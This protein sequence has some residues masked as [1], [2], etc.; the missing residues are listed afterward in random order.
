MTESK[1]TPG[2]WVVKHYEG[3]TIGVRQGDNAPS[4]MLA[5]NPI[6]C[7]FSICNLVENADST[8]ANAE[9]IASAPDLL[10][11]NE[12]MRKAY[13]ILWKCSNER[14]NLNAELVKALGAAQVVMELNHRE[15]YN[16]EYL[17]WSA[18]DQMALDVVKAAL[19]K[20]KEL[21]N[22]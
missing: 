2:P 16:N 3:G 19:A 9:L 7:G 14:D 18:E 10:D 22:D 8:N 12:Q 21:S 20:A 4:V 5:D 17:I 13:D 6:A 1:H 15:S 11:E